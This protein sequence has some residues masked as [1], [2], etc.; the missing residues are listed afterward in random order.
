MVAHISYHPNYHLFFK[1]IV[2]MRVLKQSEYL[3]L[4]RLAQPRLAASRAANQST[5]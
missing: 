3:F 1:K 4:K 5:V 2:D